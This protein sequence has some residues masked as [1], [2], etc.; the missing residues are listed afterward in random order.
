MGR[1]CLACKE[2]TLDLVTNI[3]RATR[4]TCT[5]RIDRDRP[6]AFAAPS[7]LLFVAVCTRR[8]FSKAMY[9]TPMIRISRPP[10]RLEETVS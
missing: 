7:S 6:S 5:P 2:V 9:S 1:P 10:R 8:L 3:A 4:P